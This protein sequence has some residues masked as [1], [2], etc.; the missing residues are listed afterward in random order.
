MAIVGLIVLA[1]SLRYHTAVYS[2]LV[3][4]FFIPTPC[5]LFQGIYSGDHKFVQ[6]NAAFLLANLSMSSLNLAVL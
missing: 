1:V 5:F 6:N 2:F 3:G 4:F